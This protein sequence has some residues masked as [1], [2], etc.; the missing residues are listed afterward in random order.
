MPK[1]SG[2]FE[3]GHHGRLGTQFP[4][5]LLDERGVPGICHQNRFAGA[6]EPARYFAMDPGDEKGICALRRRKE[7]AAVASVRAI[8]R[9]TE[10]YRFQQMER[11]ESRRKA[12]TASRPR[13]NL[14]DLF[15][16]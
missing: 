13:V 5:H 6:L 12:Q 10:S 11:R 1:G 15:Q 9:K 8:A 3:K 2:R 7:P 4:R 14:P 16:I